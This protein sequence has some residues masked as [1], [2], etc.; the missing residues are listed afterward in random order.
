MSRVLVIGWDGGDWRIADPLIE[1][2]LLP[3]LSARGA[4]GRRL[5]SLV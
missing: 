2:G 3:N 5:D 1:A 4:K